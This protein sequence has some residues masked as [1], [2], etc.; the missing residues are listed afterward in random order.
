MT[1][2][3][4]LISARCGLI[5]RQRDTLVISG[6]D[7]VP[8]LQGLVTSDLRLLVDEGNGH[9]TAFVNTTGRF[10]AD[11]RILHIPDLLFLDLEP[12][13]ID[14]GLMGHLRRHIIM[15]E[16]ALDDRSDATGR[17]GLW[18][19]RAPEI[20][21]A[22]SDWEHPVADRPPFCGTWGA[23]GD[24]G[25]IVQRLPWT[26]A[27]YFEISFAREAEKVL[28][29]A[30]TKA[31]G[32]EFPHFDED[33]FDV[34]RVEAGVPAFLRELHQKVIPLEA[35]FD[36]AIAYDKGCYLGQE[37]IARLDT[38]GTPAKLLRRVVLQGDQVPESG[39]DVLP[40]DGDGRPIGSVETAVFSPERQAPVA[41]AFIKRKHNDPDATV[42][43]NGMKGTIE[44][45]PDVRDL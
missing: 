2:Y 25:L 10:L 3:E 17:L 31:A 28:V 40:E 30:L 35:T 27:P 20:L 37:I 7:A 45:L 6:P 8:W 36:D 18:G 11:A 43:I 32:D 13:A 33:L 26:K 42:S 15:E 4:S 14:G 21:D 41:L 39:D 16:V 23:L 1:S 44:V 12:G 29:D 34:L 22:L 19:D 24:L 5:T 38:L 9:R